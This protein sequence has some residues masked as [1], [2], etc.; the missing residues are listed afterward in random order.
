MKTEVIK[1]AKTVQEAIQAGLAELG[2][3]RDQVEVKILQT[4]GGILS[5]FGLGRATVKVSLCQEEGIA[6]QHVASEIIRRMGVS[7]LVSA[8]S[9]GDECRVTVSGAGKSLIG[10]R[11]EVLDALEYMLE[12]ILNKGGREDRIRVYLDVDDYRLER[13]EEL[14]AMARRKADEAVRTGSVVEITRLSPSERRVVHTYLKEYGRVETRSLG[15][16][17]NRRI[18]VYP[19]G[20]TPPEAPA[21]ERGGREGREGRPRHRRRRPE[22]ASEGRPDRPPRPVSANA[23]TGG[24]EATGEGHPGRRRRGRRGGRGRRRPEGDHRHADNPSN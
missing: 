8:K 2:V 24:S 15:D 5:W 22:G 6:A 11:G 10:A 19:K 12:R 18:Q 17:N 1:K 14:R 7:A 23:A 9:E 3:E 20:M 16:D 21:E 4:G 13:E